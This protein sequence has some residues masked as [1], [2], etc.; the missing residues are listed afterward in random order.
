M[1][2]KNKSIK[3]MN[4]MKQNR[5]QNPKSL[6]VDPISQDPFRNNRL[7]MFH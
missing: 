5:R 2:M 4:A 7:I 3:H 6:I 1:K